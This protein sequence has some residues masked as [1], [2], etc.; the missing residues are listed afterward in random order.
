MRWYFSYRVLFDWI[1]GL[2]SSLC[3]YIFSTKISMGF[4]WPSDSDRVAL[5]SSIMGVSAALLGL[6][7][8][9]STFLV[10]HVQHERFKLLREA[11]SWSEFPHLVKSCLWRLFALTIFSGIS[12]LCTSDGFHTLAPVLIFLI[13]ISSLSVAALVWV[14][15]AI[16]SIQDL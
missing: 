3:F 5:A 4:H 16:I 2:A 10:G 12:A 14:V 1:A 11:R 8:A 9:A 7:L 13:V 6:V 15:S